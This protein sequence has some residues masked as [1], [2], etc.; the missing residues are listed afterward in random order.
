MRGSC[1]SILASQH[2]ISPSPLLVQRTLLPQV[3]QVYR[4]PNWFAM[5]NPLLELHRLAAATNTADAAL[6]Y[7]EFGLA[8]RADIALAGLVSHETR[9]LLLIRLS[10][11]LAGRFWRFNFRFSVAPPPGPSGAIHEHAGQPGQVYAAES[12]SGP[13]VARCD[14]VDAAAN[15]Q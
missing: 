7:Y 11:I 6:G 13:I 8:L 2:S 3:S 5:L 14:K 1:N 10:V 15:A 4:F 12:G 9:S